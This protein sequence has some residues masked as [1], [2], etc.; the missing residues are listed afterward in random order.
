MSTINLTAQE[1]G[2]RRFYRSG[3]RPYEGTKYLGKPCHA[4]KG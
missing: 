4:G 1:K 3:Q 2:C